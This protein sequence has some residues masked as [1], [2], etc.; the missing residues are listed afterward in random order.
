[1]KKRTPVT[2]SAK[3][4]PNLKAC[5]LL[6]EDPLGG[7]SLS[8]FQIFVGDH[9]SRSRSIEYFTAQDSRFSLFDEEMLK[10]LLTNPGV[11]IDR[12]IPQKRVSE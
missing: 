2:T 11:A 9:H 6:F 3:H 1:V 12:T 4:P 8:V 7:H 5:A 10:N